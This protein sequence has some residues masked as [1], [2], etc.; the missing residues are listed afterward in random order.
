[1]Q[2]SLQTDIES[3]LATLSKRECDVLKLS[4]GIGHPRAF[5]TEEIAI[6]MDLSIERVR[7]IHHRGLQRLQ[8]N[9]A[10]ESLRAY[11]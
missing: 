8:R 4:F 7:Q 5:S 3:L 2:E 10:C 11:L 1:M 6:R 9:S